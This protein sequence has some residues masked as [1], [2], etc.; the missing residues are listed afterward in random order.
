M[1]KNYLFIS[2]FWKLVSKCNIPY[3]LRYINIDVIH[4]I[5]IKRG[6]KWKKIVPAHIWLK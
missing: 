4:V 3:W 5:S 1:R 6:L 2:V